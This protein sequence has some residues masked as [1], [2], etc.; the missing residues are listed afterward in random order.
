MIEL[1]LEY[2][3]ELYSAVEEEKESRERFL[4]DLFNDLHMYS[5]NSAKAKICALLSRHYSGDK[6]DPKIEDFELTVLQDD[7]VQK[8]GMVRFDFEVEF[9][10]GCA[11]AK[12]RQLGHET[13]RYTIDEKSDILTVLFP[14]VEER[15]TYEEF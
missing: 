2:D 5:E 3:Q 8:T 14:K 11:E 1:E 10:F 9:W 6:G 4:S 12:T 13:V 15:S 7:R